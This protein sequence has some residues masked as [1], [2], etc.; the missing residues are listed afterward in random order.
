MTQQSKRISRRSFIAAGAAA[1]ASPLVLSSS[2]LGRDGV[3][4]PSERIVTA[5]IGYGNEGRSIMGGFLGDQSFHVVA[6]CDCYKK[7]LNE[8]IDR[9]N[10]HYR[11]SDCKGYHKYEELYERKDVDAIA[12][13]APDH[14]H[15]KLSVEACQ[16]GKD[17]YC[18]K[19]LTLTPME[20]RQ[21]VAAARKYNRVCT[22]GSQRVMQDYGYMA[23]VIQSGAIGEITEAYF[24]ESRP[25]ATEFYGPEQPIPEG[26]DW[27]RWLGPAPWGPYNS[28][29]CSGSYGGGW[30]LL[31]DYGNGFLADW[32]AHKLGGLL[33]CAGIDHLEP[34]EI[35][36]QKSTGDYPVMPPGLTLIYNNNGKII[37]V[38]HAVSGSHDFH[39]RFVGTEGTYEYQKDRGR[40]LP[41]K[42]VE[43]RRYNG[44]TT[45]IHADFAYSVKNRLRPFQDFF[46]GAT[47]AIAL[48]LANIA[49]K[50]QRPLKWDAAK[51]QFIGDEQAN[52][53]V[54]RPKRSPY[55]INYK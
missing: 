26:F 29:R 34:V 8:G 51:T 19:P 22:S 4:A 27:D 20:N 40:I 11:N 44:G 12:I 39:V 45:H 53:F 31:W 35:I 55:E 2:V 46:Y 54:S 38:H 36:P 9:V 21:I 52:R 6:V 48:Q 3:Y 17:V 30:R 14:W 47:T 41:L 7:H 50:C 43:L 18:E 1:A 42:P 10:K 5:M 13:A 28:N 24:F 33:Y 25:L 23:P 16:N 32:G 37:K 49:Y 15:T